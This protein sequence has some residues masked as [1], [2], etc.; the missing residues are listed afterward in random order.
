[1]GCGRRVIITLLVSQTFAMTAS[2]DDPMASRSATNAIGGVTR[3]PPKPGRGGH[4]LANTALDRVTFAIDGAESSHGAD[5][6]MW[7]PNPS[8]PQGPMQVSQA[9]SVDVGG[10]DR[11]DLTQNRAIGRAYLARL[12]RRYN[13][14]PDAIAAYNWGSGNVDVWV[15]AGRPTEKLLIGVAGY[16]RRVLHDSGLCDASKAKQPP[17]SS[18]FPNLPDGRKA[19][20]T[21]L[22]QST[23]AHLDPS[24]Q[25][26]NRPDR[27]SKERDPAPPRSLL[28]QEAQS[29]RSSWNLA[30][31]YS[32]ECTTT[33]G[34]SLAC[35]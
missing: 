7:R 17:R 16:L 9:A 18:K 31:R 35:R 6:A 29:A 13:N 21:R 22:A 34:T 27:F 33:S 28:E 23:C 32:L 5:I 24:D 11:F 14:W 26:S 2:A 30:M 12:Y 1:M 25:A 15:K 4:T 8:G 3:S 10:G 19:L 20:E